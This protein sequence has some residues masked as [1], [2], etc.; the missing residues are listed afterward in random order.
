MPLNI[1]KCSFGFVI[2]ILISFLKQ[3]N[4]ILISFWGIKNHVEYL[5]IQMVILMPFIEKHF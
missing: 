2:H 3:G 1:R 4:K 5:F